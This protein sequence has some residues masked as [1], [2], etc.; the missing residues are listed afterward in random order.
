M[1]QTVLLIHDDAA[2]ARTVKDSLLGSP[3]GF[4]IVEW[5]ERCS[6]A[7]RRLRKDGKEHIDAIM[8]NLFLPDSRGLETFNRIFQVSC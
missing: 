5:V 6:E 3:D 4:F 1:P 7:V 8:L 2:K